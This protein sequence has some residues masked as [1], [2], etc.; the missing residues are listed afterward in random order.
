MKSIGER[1]NGRLKKNSFPSPSPP[2]PPPPPPA[3]VVV[4]PL[5]PD[6]VMLS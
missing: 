4:V 6:G 5:A 1:M 2:P 3:V